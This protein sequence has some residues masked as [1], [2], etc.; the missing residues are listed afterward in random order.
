MPPIQKRLMQRVPFPHAAQ[1]HKAQRVLP[2]DSAFGKQVGALPGRSG[3]GVGRGENSA[4]SCKGMREGT[5]QREASAAGGRS[6]PRNQ[7]CLPATRG[8]REEVDGGGR[9]V[10]PSKPRSQDKQESTASYHEVQGDL[11]GPLGRYLLPQAPPHVAHRRACDLE[12]AGQL[13]LP[14]AVDGPPAGVLEGW[15]E[16]TTPGGIRRVRLSSPG[17]R[18]ALFAGSRRLLTRGTRG[19]LLGTRLDS[20]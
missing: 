11:G 17:A 9:G 14:V 15:G 3:G 8:P 20:R 12:L 1:S 5:L 16:D 6:H 4:A 13:Y 19:E 18:E 2:G 7:V 10:E